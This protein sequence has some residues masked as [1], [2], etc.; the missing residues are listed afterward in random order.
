[1]KLRCDAAATAAAAATVCAPHACT[2]PGRSP[3]QMAS[4]IRI[5]TSCLVRRTCALPTVARC[6]RAIVVEWRVCYPTSGSHMRA[7]TMVVVVGAY[8]TARS[9][10]PSMQVILR[11]GWRRWERGT[12][13]LIFVRLSVSFLLVL[14]LPRDGS[15]WSPGL[16]IWH[17]PQKAFGLA[18]ANRDR[19]VEK[20]RACIAG[21]RSVVAHPHIRGAL[22]TEQASPSLDEAA[23]GWNAMQCDAPRASVAFPIPARSGSVPPSHFHFQFKLLLT[24]SSVV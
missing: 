9:D 23:G 21:E 12:D 2:P 19:A 15:Q 22:A 16:A 20:E 24:V 6:D 4:G 7:I 5:P 1:M 13:V 3:A 18:G 17:S 8:F 14:L 10:N 11:A